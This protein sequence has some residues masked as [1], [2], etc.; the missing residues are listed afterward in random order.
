M[1]KTLMFSEEQAD[2]LLAA[3]AEDN[4]WPASWS[5]EKCERAE[6]YIADLWSELETFI[7]EAEDARS[8]H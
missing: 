6:Q 3:I 8:E 5:A 2:Y 7:K 4:L 1:I